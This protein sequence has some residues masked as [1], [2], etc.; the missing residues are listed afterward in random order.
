MYQPGLVLGYREFAPE[1]TPVIFLSTEKRLSGNRDTLHR[2]SADIVWVRVSHARSYLSFK[3]QVVK[4]LEGYYDAYH[5]MSS[6]KELVGSAP[7]KA[8]NWQ[9][10][11]ESE[12]ELH[13]VAWLEDAP[14]LGFEKTDYGRRYYRPIERHHVW[15]DVPDLE[16]E[17]ASRN[18][19][20]FPYEARREL[21]PINHAATIVWNS[22]RSDDDNAEA[23]ALFE[24][25][26]NAGTRSVFETGIEVQSD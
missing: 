17:G 9:I 22:S 11:K 15:H 13:V 6:V 10:E 16:V 21:A 2:D 25:M 1:N 14:T 12:L 23:L 24:Q 26:A 18:F 8:K 5:F 20:N 3:G 7:A 19:K 4:R